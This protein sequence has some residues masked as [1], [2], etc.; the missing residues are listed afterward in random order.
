MVGKGNIGGAVFYV[1]KQVQNF[2]IYQNVEFN[3]QA[4]KHENRI[5]DPLAKFTGYFSLNLFSIKNNAG[6]ILRALETRKSV[7]LTQFSH[8]L[9]SFR[10]RS[11]VEPSATSSKLESLDIQVV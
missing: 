5:V 8:Y 9:L 11:S 1:N 6:N 3:W 7:S 2:E 4:F 10:S